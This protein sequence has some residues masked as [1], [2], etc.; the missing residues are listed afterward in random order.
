MTPFVLKLYLSA[1]AYFL[2]QVVLLRYQVFYHYA[3]CYA[4]VHFLLLFPLQFNKSVYI[5]TA[6]AYGLLIDMVYDSLGMHM[7][8]CGLLA[9]AR[10]GMVMLLAPDLQKTGS[11]LVHHHNFGLIWYLTYSIPLLFLHHTYLAMLDYSDFS[12]WWRILL[13]GGASTLFSLAVILLI[14]NVFYR[15][16][17][18]RI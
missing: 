2:M 17:I 12:H 6:F 8:A 7:A 14:Q 18:E 9:F 15:Q 11:L 10:E 5:I 4:Y 3:V 13:T 1:L 16:T